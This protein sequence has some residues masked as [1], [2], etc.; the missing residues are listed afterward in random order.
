MNL[1]EEDP[2]FFV[3]FG[4]P[5]VAASRPLPW[6]LPAFVGIYCY[7]EIAFQAY[8]PERARTESRLAYSSVMSS[9]ISN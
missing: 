9:R 8:T 4:R 7:Y 2:K 3:N 1:E 5:Q 6:E